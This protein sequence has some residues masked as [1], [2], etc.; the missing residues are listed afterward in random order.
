MRKMTLMGF[1]KSKKGSGAPVA[2]KDDT[3]FPAYARR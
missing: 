1:Q 2:F 3:N